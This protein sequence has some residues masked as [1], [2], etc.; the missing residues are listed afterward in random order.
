MKS[1]NYSTPRPTGDTLPD[2]AHQT[3]SYFPGCS[4]ATSA[5]EN[6]ASLIH[7][8]KRMGIDLVEVEDWNCCGSSSA[9][10]ID[11]ELAEQLP[12]RNLS[13]APAGRP[14][15][16][17][18]PSCFLRLKHC[19]L[20]LRQD[21]GKRRQYE[22]DFG[23][24]IDPD[25]NILHFFEVLDQL[26][27][28]THHPHPLRRLN[29]LRC[30]PYYGCMLARPPEMKS[31]KTHSGLMEKIL[32][33]FGAEPLQW[34]YASRCCGTF[35]SVARPDIVTEM[36]NRII[37]DAIRCRADCIVTACA[38]C[39]MNLEIRCNLSRPIPILHFSELLSLAM[40]TVP[41]KD[42]FQR[43]LIDPR[44]VLKTRALI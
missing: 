27:L 28:G 21:T 42:W 43:H 2:Q 13:L 36:V 12:A 6:N 39:H 32:K 33:N 31:E 17:A 35:L 26:D 10:S 30:A 16:V 34:A 29:G 4:L 5:K 3:Y 18:C 22:K 37:S 15:M 7:F 41:E 24:A 25:L 44:P 9:H 1:R 14:L 8:F 20:K 23:R 11:A 38:M 40:G 19:Q